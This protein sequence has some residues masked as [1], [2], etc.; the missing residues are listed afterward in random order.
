V[1]LH[2]YLSEF[3]YLVNSPQR[4]TKSPH[5][6][7]FDERFETETIGV[8]VGM[9]QQLKL[10]CALFRLMSRANFSKHAECNFKQLNTNHVNSRSPFLV[11]FCDF[12]WVHAP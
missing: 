6:G 9:S 5:A 2:L 7:P 8:A 3:L 1:Y 11:L 10:Y 4:T 12:W